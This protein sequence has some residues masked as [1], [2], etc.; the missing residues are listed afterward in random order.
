[1][2]KICKRC[3]LPI[4]VN[5][6]ISD[7]LEDMHW[8]CFHL[9]FEHGDYDPDEPCDDPS[10]PW[11]RISGKNISIIYSHVSDIKIIGLDNKSGI[12]IDKKEIELYGMPSIKAE[13]ILHDENFRNY[14]RNIWLEEE[15]LKIFLKQLKDIWDTGRGEATLKAMSED[16]FSMKIMNIDRLGHIA[17][18]YKVKSY[19]Y[20]KE[21]IIHSYYENGF[22]VEFSSLEKLIKDITKLLELFKGK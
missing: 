19:K 8:L 6:D 4:K 16:D 9:E 15:F 2:D 11:N 21:Q 14:S 3:G 18:I 10:C 20:V 22:E 7:V 13:I 1:V 12:F 17:T 5:K